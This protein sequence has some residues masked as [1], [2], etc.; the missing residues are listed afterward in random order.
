MFNRRSKDFQMK[1]SLY[2]AL[3][4]TLLF[5]GGTLFAQSAAQWA[6]QQKDALAAFNDAS[7]ADTL[8]QGEP[9]LEKLFAEVKTGGVSDPLVLTHIAAIT[10][11]V[12]KKDKRCLN[13]PRFMARV[14][15]FFQCNGAAKQ[16]KV[17]T[18]A[19][20]AAAQR[21]TDVDVTCFFLDQ[22]RWCGLPEQA[23]AIKAFE[24]SNSKDVAALAVM[25]VQAVTDDRAS[26]AAPVTPTRYATLNKELAALDAKALT[27]RLL[28]AFDDPDL[29]YAGVALNWARTTGGKAETALW[30]GKLAAA[31]DPVR[32]TMLLDMLGGRNDTDACDAVAALL[33]D[34]DIGVASAAHRALLRLSPSAFAA[35]LPTLLKDLQEDRV[36]L[37]RDSARVLPTGLLKAPILSAYDSLNDTGKKVAMDLLK[38]RH[39][40]EASRFALATLDAKDEET[41]IAGYRFLRETA[42]AEHADL[43]IAKLLAAKGRVTP[44]VQSAIAASARRDTSGT[45]VKTLTG[46]LQTAPDASK[47]VVLETA[48]RIG[49]A[50]LLQAVEAAS[51]SANIEVST[52][53]IR[54]LADWPENTVLPALLR[55]AVTAPDA[56]RQILATR[57]VSKMAS[58]DGFDKQKYLEVWRKL[59]TQPGDDAR[60]KEIDTFFSEEVNVALGKPV[61]AN[62][63]QQGEYAPQFL[64]DGT[65][66]KAWHGAKWPA[67]IQ[68]D[69]GSA[70]PVHAAHVTFFHDGR[71]YTFTLELSED[72]KTWNQVAGNTTAPKPAT[73]EGLRLN[74]P[75]TPARYVR[76]NVLKNSQNEAVHVLELKVFQAVF[77]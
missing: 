73:A 35:K 26:K 3:V 59:R 31:T 71:T 19:L 16:R 1:H 41:V 52:A 13:D 62:V 67:Q 2:P 12:M 60:K 20:L 37:V 55:L 68:V 34:T 27:P 30:T 74:F 77:K 33:T 70:I 65:V 38:D 25:T 58:K 72:G 63:P 44:E 43:L 40:T 51:A 23:E 4:A 54:A 14:G 7:L 50:P 10:Q 47:P 18:D 61:T 29:A 22:L 21:A 56:K 5:V 76:L 11:Y 8:K 64:V 45:Y 48:A 36:P 17:Y 28:A 9:A 49:G 69:L 53:A 32:K 6:E 42:S 15:N 46:T 57:G 75:A 24:K 66:E 39:V